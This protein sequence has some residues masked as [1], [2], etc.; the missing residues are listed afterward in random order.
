MSPSVVSTEEVR[1][2]FAL[3]G[4][5]REIK[6]ARGS[7]SCHILVRLGEI[8]HAQIGMEMTVVPSAPSTANWIADSGWPSAS[9]RATVLEHLTPRDAGEDEVPSASCG[10]V[11]STTHWCSTVKCATV[12]SPARV[13]DSLVTIVRSRP[14]P[15]SMGFGG[16]LLGARPS[17]VRAVVFKRSPGEPVFGEHE[18]SLVHLFLSEFHW[19][20]AQPANAIEPLSGQTLSP[21]ER[22]ILQLLLTGKPEKLVAA[23]LGIS[24]HT[25]H[26]YVKIVYRKM[27]VTSRAELMARALHS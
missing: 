15:D 24:R 23:A 2:L 9:D 8:L 12:H 22:D 27:Q 18:R 17:R 4:E 5:V 13:N 26:Q 20:Y 7:P 1:A 19:F 6:A 11:T 16:G 3:V 25:A 10:E 14:R 21:R